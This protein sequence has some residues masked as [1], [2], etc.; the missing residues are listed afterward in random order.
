[1]SP[2]PASKGFGSPVSMRAAV[3]S[4]ARCGACLALELWD[5]IP[6]VSRLDLGDSDASG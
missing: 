2:S 3:R 4:E 5:A 6:L 1:M